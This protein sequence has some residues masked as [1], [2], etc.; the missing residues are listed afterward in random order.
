VTDARW[1]TRQGYSTSLHSQYVAAGWLEQS[2][3]G[4]Y[5]RPRGS[6]GWQQV[7]V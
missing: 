6:L 2:A 1:L 7:V 4:V 5:R 3:R